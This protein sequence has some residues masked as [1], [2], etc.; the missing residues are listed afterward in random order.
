MPGN[1]GLGKATVL[2]LAGHGIDT[3][4]TY[5]SNQAEA[6][7]VVAEVAKAGCKAVALQLDVGKTT[8]FDDFVIQVR[9]TLTQWDRTTFDFL[10]NNAGIGL[11]APL[12]S[13]TEAQFDEL[14]NVHFKGPVFLTQKLLPLMQDGGRIV[15]ISTG[16]ARFS[17]PGRGVYGALKGAVE[18]WTRYLAQ[19]LSPRR[20]AANTVAP[21]PIAT[22]FSG[23]M[24]R[25]NKEIS[26]ALASHT[27]LGRVGVAEDIG[28]VV[29]FLCTPD[30]RWINGQRIEA[31]GGIHL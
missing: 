26:A 18:V 14:S 23:G 5:R 19:E 6:A 29:A 7:D 21:G 24:V 17:S 31:A 11:A 3:V 1:R 30:A 10:V 22:D 2:S 27:A 12:A 28:G 4:F 15:N 13:I 8:T 16:L 25:D 9:S 20:I